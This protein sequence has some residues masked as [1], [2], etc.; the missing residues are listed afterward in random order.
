MIAEEK[1]HDMR[2]GD[3]REAGAVTRLLRQAVSGDRSALEELESH[4]GPVLRRQAEA[5]MRQ[6]RSGHTLQATVLIDETYL[7]LMDAK[8]LHLNDRKHFYA[9]ASR[10]MWRVLRE[11]AQKHS[12]L[13]RGSGAARLSLDGVDPEVSGGRPIEFLDLDAAVTRLESIDSLAAEVVKLRILGERTSE[14]VGEILGIH[15]RTVKRKW[16]AARQQLYDYLKE[17]YGEA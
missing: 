7:A 17:A 2:N 6:E 10:I 8:G 1:S 15:A 4:V 11:Y 5:L 12:A 14:E 16:K 13:K 9:I 3:D